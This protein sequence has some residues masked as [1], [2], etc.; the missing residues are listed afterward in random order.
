MQGE[1][2]L[3]GEDVL[4]A[5]TTFSFDI[6]GLEIYLPL[7]TGARLV[8]ASSEDVVDGDRLKDLLSE[9]QATV[10]QATPPPGDCS[11]K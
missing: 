10:M 1:P 5:V 8:V 6:A 4:L 9:S 11:W 7:I 3:T 2:G